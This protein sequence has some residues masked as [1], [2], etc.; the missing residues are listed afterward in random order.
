MRLDYMQHL[1]VPCFNNLCLDFLPSYYL[2]QN[3]PIVKLW[4]NTFL[5]I[6]SKVKHNRIDSTNLRPKERNHRLVAYK[7]G[8]RL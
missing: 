1:K 3:V 6:G 5:C 7:I 8:G 4:E 2:G